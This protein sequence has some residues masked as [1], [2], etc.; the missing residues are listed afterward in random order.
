MSEVLIQTEYE[1]NLV[2][3]FMNEY[4]L[5]PSFYTRTFPIYYLQK[6]KERSSDI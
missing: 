1:K 4:L 2:H 5:I 3:I 6:K